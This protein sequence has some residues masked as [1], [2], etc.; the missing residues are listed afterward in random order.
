LPSDTSPFEVEG[1]EAGALFTTRA[2]DARGTFTVTEEN[3]AAIAELCAHLDGNALA[4][5]LA[6]ARTAMMSPSEILA[7]LDQRFRLL[8][9]RSGETAERH[10][11]LHAAIDW[12]YALLDDEEQT[13]LQ[14]LSV[15]VG[16]FDLAAA[17]AVATVAGLDELDAVDRLGSLVAK[18]LVERNEVAERS[19]YRLLETIRQYAVG[20]LEA[21]GDAVRAHDAHASHY[22]AAARE[23]FAMLETPRD[24]EA[25]EQLRLEASNLAAGLRWL[26]ASDHL[27]EVLAFFADA[28]FFDTGL[29][30]FAL[31]D[32]LGRLAD[33]ALRREG[34]S[35]VRGY[36]EAAFYAGIRAM[37]VGDWERYRD[38]GLLGIA[39][40]PDSPAMLGLRMG[41]VSMRGDVESAVSMGRAAVEHA[42]RTDDPRL[43]SFMLALLALTELMVDPALGLTHADEAVE[44]ARRSPASSTLI[45]PLCQLSIAAQHSDPD[46][47]LAAAE[48]CVRLDRSH[49]KTWSRLTEGTIVTLRVDR[50][51]LAA[52]LTLWRDFLH[53]LHWSGEVF[54]LGVQIPGLADSIAGID[55]KLGLEFAAIAESGAIIPSAPFALPGLERLADAVDELGPDALRAARALAASMTYDESLQYVFDGLDRIITEVAEP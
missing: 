31:L 24:F 32:E 51:E 25:L 41:E 13:L 4:I 5:E 12:S 14:W 49:R 53:R 55:S 17:T 22:L 23:L 6:A 48:E 18:S 7:R 3:A 20:R 19:R 42:R 9:S 36:V 2:R 35:Q 26:L 52:G 47:A 27:P 15:F 30:P 46:L 45:Y 10:Q 50:G 34:A 16:E 43:L 54:F 38:V 8:K 28:G 21:D 33:E 44:V 39:A 1:S 40:D 37:S 29:V 11:T